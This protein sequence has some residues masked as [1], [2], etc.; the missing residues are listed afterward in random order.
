[1]WFTQDE[2][3]TAA[4]KSVELDDML[5]GA[6]VQHRETQEYESPQFLSLFKGGQKR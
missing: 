3:G 4:I 6:P 1:M 5:G 2:K